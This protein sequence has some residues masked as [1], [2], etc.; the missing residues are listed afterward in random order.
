MAESTSTPPTAP[1][2]LDRIMLG[3]TAAAGIFLFGFPVLVTPSF[4]VMFEDFGAELPGLTVL[5][6][7]GWFTPLL[8]LVALALGVAGFFAR[9]KGSPGALALGFGGLLL[10][11]G[12]ICL[13]VLGLYLPLFAL[14]N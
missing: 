12:G 4:V 8:G 7:S 11:V 10:A 5:A 6:V 9:S 1:A 3:I 2:L 13:G 14:A